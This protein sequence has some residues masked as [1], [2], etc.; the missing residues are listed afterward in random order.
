MDMDET[1][2]DDTRDDSGWRTQPGGARLS[3]FVD[4]GWSPGLTSTGSGGAGVLCVADREGARSVVLVG[5]A[6]NLSR[7]AAVLK[8]WGIPA[9]TSPAVL[10][11][12]A[13]TVETE[14]DG[15]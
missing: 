2:R 15:R 5:D 6:R 10:G 11:L 4:D 1:A 14:G 3:A 8:A 9:K 12:N 7:L 13:S